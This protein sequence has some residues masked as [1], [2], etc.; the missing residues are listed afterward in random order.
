[1]VSQ[2]MRRL[3]SPIAT[4]VCMLKAMYVI[5]FDMESLSSNVEGVLAGFG[6]I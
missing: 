6:L 5:P 4:H 2:F 1:M 3:S